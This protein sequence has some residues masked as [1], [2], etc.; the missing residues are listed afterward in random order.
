MGLDR[1]TDLKKKQ[2]LNV[3]QHIKSGSNYTWFKLLV[4]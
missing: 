3:D 2:V 1:S 4:C